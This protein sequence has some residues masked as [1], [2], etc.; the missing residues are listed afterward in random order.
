MIN[1][2]NGQRTHSTKMGADKLAKIPQMPQN[3]SAQILGLLLLGIGTC[4]FWSPELSSI[5][6]TAPADPNS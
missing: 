3:L 2:K 4:G 5:E 1:G 6:Q